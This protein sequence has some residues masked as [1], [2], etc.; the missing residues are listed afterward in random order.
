MAA[1]AERDGGSK[2]R[3][4]RVVQAPDRR[5]HAQW[6]HR[7]DER[8]RRAVGGLAVIADMGLRQIVQ[9]RRRT[10]GH[11][12]RRADA[13]EPRRLERRFRPCGREGPRPR[14]AR[15]RRRRAGAARARPGRAPP[16]RRSRHAVS[17]KAIHRKGKSRSRS[18]SGSSSSPAAASKARHRR[19]G[20]LGRRRVTSSA[21]GLRPRR[22]AT[23]RATSA[24]I[25]PASIAVA[26]SSNA[27][28]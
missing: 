24:T 7:V 5:R 2:R 27:C 18:S 8:P 28:R 23:T 21:R 4:V 15:P 6:L 1:W 17:G 14:R 16:G 11:A 12:E 13:R 10:H 22:D 3:V 20:V 9:R 26:A 25:A 19:P